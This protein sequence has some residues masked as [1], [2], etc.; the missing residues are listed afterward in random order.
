M[1]DALAHKQLTPNI[2]PCET[3][4]LIIRGIPTTDIVDVMWIKD[5]IRC[6]ACLKD[7]VIMEGIGGYWKGYT[8]PQVKLFVAHSSEICKTTNV[9]FSS[10]SG[11]R[12]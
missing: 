12:N 6:I 11:N 9:A 7:G 4:I 3:D 8:H 5:E 1:I 2:G 10:G